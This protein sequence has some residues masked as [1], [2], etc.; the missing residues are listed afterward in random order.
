M[1]AA[2]S[3]P[4]FRA[5]LS[6]ERRLRPALGETYSVALQVAA[7]PVTLKAII[8]SALRFES[9]LS[10]R[11]YYYGSELHNSRFSINILPE[12]NGM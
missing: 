7:D 2:E 9:E 12:V 1:N 11:R 6:S 3:R 4:V 10:Q 5:P 8:G